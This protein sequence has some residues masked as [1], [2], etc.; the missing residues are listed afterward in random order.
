MHLSTQKPVYRFQGDFSP[1]GPHNPQLS[2]CCSLLVYRHQSCGTTRRRLRETS[3][4][5]WTGV[6][7]PLKLRPAQPRRRHSQR[8]AGKAWGLA[9]PYVC[10][11]GGAIGADVSQTA[12]WATRLLTGTRRASP[13]L[14]HLVPVWVFPRTRLMF[15]DSHIPGKEPREN[16]PVLC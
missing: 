5:P 8:R 9:A 11:G 10:W 2:S 13:S 15:A 1:T 3:F 14:D 6:Q 12:W 4:I 16:V 7:G